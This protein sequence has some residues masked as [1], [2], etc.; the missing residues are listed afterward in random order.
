M[1]NLEQ[2]Y[3]YKIMN[4]K[5]DSGEKNNINNNN[6]IDIKIDKFFSSFYKKSISGFKLNYFKNFDQLVMITYN[7]TLSSMELYINEKEVI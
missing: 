6:K 5:C 3:K 7:M 2:F 1:N 4:I